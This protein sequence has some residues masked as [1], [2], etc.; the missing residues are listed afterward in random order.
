MSDSNYVQ[1]PST[2]QQYE[3]LGPDGTTVTQAPT[4][5]DPNVKQGKKRLGNNYIPTWNYLPIQPKTGKDTNEIETSAPAQFLA[6][7]STNISDYPVADAGFGEDRRG[8]LAEPGNPQV[9]YIVR[10]KVWQDPYLKKF[11]SIEE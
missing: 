2:T 11:L 6:Q 8:K 9:R 4:I 1:N 7:P 10:S 5:E 3:S